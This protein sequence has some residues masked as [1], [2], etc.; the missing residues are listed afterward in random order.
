[1]WAMF[2]VLRKQRPPYVPAQAKTMR[3]AGG[4]TVLY[5]EFAAPSP[6]VA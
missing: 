5:I 1:M 6:V 4:Q 3:L 2:A